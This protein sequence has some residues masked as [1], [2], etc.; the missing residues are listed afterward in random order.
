ML[1]LELISISVP[2]LN[3][4]ALLDVDALSLRSVAVVEDGDDEVENAVLV[5][6]DPDFVIASEAWRSRLLL[7]AS[8]RRDA[9]TLVEKCTAFLASESAKL[10]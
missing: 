9:A 8:D 10:R 4:A 3:I 7:G 1:E 6:A 2:A 5:I